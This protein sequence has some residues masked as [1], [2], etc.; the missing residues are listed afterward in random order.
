MRLL[1]IYQ[2]PRRTFVEFTFEDERTGSRQYRYVPA[3][4]MLHQPVFSIPSHCKVEV[5]QIEGNI[6]PRLIVDRHVLRGR[7]GWWFGQVVEKE[8]YSFYIPSGTFFDATTIAA[9]ERQ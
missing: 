4:R 1:P 5:C 8:R 7:L 9:F 3:S 6:H 2:K